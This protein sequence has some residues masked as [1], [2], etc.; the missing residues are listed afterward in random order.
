MSM[1]DPVADLLTRIRNA[2]SV[3]KDS[4]DVPLSKLK[5]G[6]AEVLK[7]EGY[8]ND[9]KTLDVEGKGFLRIYL[10]YGPEGEDIIV[11]IQKVSRPGRRVYQG[12]ADLKP[13]L[14]GI[15]ISV[16][17]TPQGVLSDIECRER[18]VGGEVLAE[19]Y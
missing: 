16:V 3:R 19:I 4:V 10:K 1:T 15:G 6:V 18:N 12:C 9:I 7:R 14:R 2:L 13:I 11:S 5:R 8:I 17:S